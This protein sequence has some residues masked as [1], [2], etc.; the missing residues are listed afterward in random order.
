MNNNG[1]IKLHRKMLD[2]TWYDDINTKV[3]FLHL[4]LTANYEDKTWHGIQIKRGQRLISYRNL[5]D[6]CGVTLQTVRTS[7][8]KLKS[9]HE[10]TLETTHNYTLVTIVNYDKY[11]SVEKI[12]TQQVTQELTHEQHSSNTNI[13]NNKKYKEINKEK[14]YLIDNRENN[15]E[16][17]YE[18]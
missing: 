16:A 10:I 18:N 15:L 2:W 3:V 1:F 9:T 14:F 13:R 11:Q 6:E 4:L 7:V 8:L 12:S 17:I 5:A